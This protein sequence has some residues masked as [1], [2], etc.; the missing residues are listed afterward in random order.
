MNDLNTRKKQGV[1]AFR[2]RLGKVQIPVALGMTV[3]WMLLF[4]GFQPRTE[5]LG[6]ALLGF[7]VSVAIM[8]VFPLPPI[9]PGFR[10]WPVQGV[11]MFFYVLVK[12]AVASFQVTAQV[13][14][15]GPPVKSSVVSVRLRTDS[16]LMLVCTAITVSVI[17]GSVIVEVAQPE[18]VLYVHVL[19]AESEAEAEKAKEDILELEERIVRALGTRENIAELEAAQAAG[20]GNT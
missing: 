20:K 8:M 3:V 5:S 1:R 6:I 11:R 15:P 9:V 18:H 16:D 4:D 7:T 17:P 14:R 12:M 10:F 2:H 13:F 19:G